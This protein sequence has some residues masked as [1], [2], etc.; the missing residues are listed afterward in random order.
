MKNVV[1]YTDGGCR[2][3]GKEGAVGGY[4]VVLM[5]NDG[6]QLHKKELKKSFVNV[7]NNQMELQAVIDCLKSLKEPC[8]VTLT[9]DSRYVCDAINKKWLQSWEMRG[10]VTASKQ[11]VK[12]KEQWQELSTLLH[13]HMVNFVWVKGHADNEYNNRCDELA[14]LAM[15]EINECT[16]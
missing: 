1:C 15:D 8:T 6:K 3:N 16:K 10:W 7:T 13:Q 9:S 14:N 2:G 5:Y 4:G 11:P 12:N